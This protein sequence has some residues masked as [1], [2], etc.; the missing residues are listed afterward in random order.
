[1]TPVGT[2]STPET[3]ATPSE[4]YQ[5]LQQIPLQCHE[6]ERLYQSELLSVQ[7]YPERQLVW[8]K[9]QMAAP[10]TQDCYNSLAEG[11]K[12]SLPGVSKVILDI[13]YEGTAV[14]AG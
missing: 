14:S 6:Q 8:L 13:H 5:F 11:L 9:L 4:F 10:V 7:V 12:A 1:M 2:Q 3:E